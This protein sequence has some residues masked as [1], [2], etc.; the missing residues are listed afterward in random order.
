[1]PTPEEMQ[2]FFDEQKN[3]PGAVTPPSPA[4]FSP[5]DLASYGIKTDAPSPFAKPQEQSG[6]GQLA[7]DLKILPHTTETTSQERPVV[8]PTVGPDPG[9]LPTPSQPLQPSGPPIIPGRY[10]AA[11]WDKSRLPWKPETIKA[12][13]NAIGQHEQAADQLTSA[14]SAQQDA[15]DRFHQEQAAKAQERAA[16][17]YQV[18]Q[19]RQEHIKQQTQKYQDFVDQAGS[20]KVDPDRYL[21][22]QGTGTRILMAIGAGL[23]GFVSDKGGTN[24][25]LD[26]I[27]KNI[28]RDIQAQQQDLATKRWKSGAQMNMLGELRAQGMDERMAANTLESAQWK[29]AE[30]QLKAQLAHTESPLTQ[31][32]GAEAIAA[33]NDKR[34][35]LKMEADAIMH[36]NAQFIGGA[37]PNKVDMDKIA[38]TPDGKFVMARNDKVA[39]DLTQMSAELPKIQRYFNEALTI[40]EKPLWWTS[41]QDLQR[42]R[43]LQTLTAPLISKMG[44]N[45]VLRDAEREAMNDSVTAFTSWT[46]G[47]SEN[48]KK[49]RDGFVANVN[50]AFKAQAAPVVDTGYSYDARGNI[51]PVA[52]FK[53]ENLNPK[54]QSMPSG[55]KKIGP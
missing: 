49:S 47:T 6:W 30:E 7:S 3:A 38:R 25:M 37:Q 44:D 39:Q 4:P 55:A 23:G 10:V 9:G 43:S 41:P 1:M 35:G 34:V 48:M 18:E 20:E 13:E 36:H 12:A 46:P 42:L 28:D 33:F 19:S 52:G 8:S 11:G 15:L 2:R 51:V 40:R 53:G 17:Q 45:S 21:H 32:R 29:I 24:P 31:A 16:Q 54:N 22:S 27:Q 5:E 50:D 14:L 26:M